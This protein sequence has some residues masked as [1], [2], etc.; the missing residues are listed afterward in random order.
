MTNFPD[1]DNS[2]LGIFNWFWKTPFRTWGIRHNSQVARMV[3]LGR[4]WTLLHFQKTLTRVPKTFSIFKLFHWDQFSTENFSTKTRAV[5]SSLKGKF[6]DK[7]KLFFQ[8][9]QKP[10]GFWVCDEILIS[11]IGISQEL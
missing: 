11:S 3:M 6:L 8:E 10:H 5:L 7:N 1:A 2:R 4:F 9:M